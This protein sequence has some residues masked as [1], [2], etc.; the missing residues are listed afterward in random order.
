MSTPA[1]TKDAKAAKTVPG[2]KVIARADR[3]RRAGRVFTAEPTL[4]P[5]SDLD[6]KQVDALRTEPMLVVQDVDV[7]APGKGEAE[8]KTE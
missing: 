4:I 7:P 2:I 3:F 1:T 5:L 6:K 8:A